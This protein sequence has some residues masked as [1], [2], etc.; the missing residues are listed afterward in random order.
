M[1]V[2]ADGKEMKFEDAVSALLVEE[3]GKTKDEADFLVTRYP[4]IM[5]E[6]MMNGMNF[7]AAAWALLMKDDE[8]L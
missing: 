3:H 7:R 8:K 4:K 5:T 2:P 1:F 6:A